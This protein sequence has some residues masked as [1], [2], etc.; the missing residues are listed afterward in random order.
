[1]NCLENDK[2]KL[3]NP[4]RC[5]RVLRL[6]WSLNCARH[7]HSHIFQ[8][9]DPS[10]SGSLQLSLKSILSEMSLFEPPNFDVFEGCLRGVVARRTNLKFADVDVE[11]SETDRA[12]LL[13][14]KIGVLNIKGQSLG[15][16][17]EHGDYW[18]AAHSQ[19]K[20][21]R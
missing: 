7:I 1:V 11:R 18:V 8:K 6:T 4:S 15:I 14:V 12:I 17:V 21:V 13:L 3:A 9:S 19:A 16:A 5:W 20:L 10:K 2:L